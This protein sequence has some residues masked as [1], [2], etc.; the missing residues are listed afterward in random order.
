MSPSYTNGIARHALET[1]L[2][3]QQGRSVPTLL[4]RAAIRRE[5]TGYPSTRTK[6]A[7]AGFNTNIARTAVLRSST[8]AHPNT[9]TQLPV[10]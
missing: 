10:C 2:P 7:R 5:K 8:I 6:R 4:R 1:R 3:R 9:G